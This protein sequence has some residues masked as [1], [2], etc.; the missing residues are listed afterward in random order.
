MRSEALDKAIQK[1]GGMS[2]LAIELGISRQAISQ[3]D[4]V[5]PL[6]VLAVEKA[7]GVPR[8]ELRPDIFGAEATPSQPDPPAERKA[9]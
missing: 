6:Q 3:W 5:P 8:Y 9:G 7:S 1:A 2:A 4:E